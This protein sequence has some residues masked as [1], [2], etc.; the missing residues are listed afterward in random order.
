MSYKLTEDQV[1]K[2]M[3]DVTITSLVRRLIDGEYN[4]EEIKAVHIQLILSDMREE[5]KK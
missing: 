5:D 4:L 1:R 3:D 2:L